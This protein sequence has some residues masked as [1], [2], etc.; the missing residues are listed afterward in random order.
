[1]FAFYVNKLQH[2]AELGFISDSELA[3]GAFQMQ[4]GKGDDSSALF[5]SIT[6]L[7]KVPRAEN[8]VCMTFFLFT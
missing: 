2:T 3:Q 7:N 8:V 6:E 1:M 4:L 5:A